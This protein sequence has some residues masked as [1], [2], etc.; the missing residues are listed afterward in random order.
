MSKV[1]ENYAKACED[2]EIL[3]PRVDAWKGFSLELVRNLL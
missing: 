3:D 1:S 2:W